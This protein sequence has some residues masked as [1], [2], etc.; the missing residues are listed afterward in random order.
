M[1]I[2]LKLKCGKDKEVNIDFRRNQREYNGTEINGETIER[3]KRYKYQGVIVED[4]LSTDN[5]AMQM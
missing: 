1:R 5:Y 4:K 3:V 2:Y